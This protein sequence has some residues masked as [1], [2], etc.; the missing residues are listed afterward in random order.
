LPEKTVAI[1]NEIG[2]FQETQRGFEG[3]CPQCISLATCLGVSCYKDTLLLLGFSNS[4]LVSQTFKTVLGKVERPIV[5]RPPDYSKRL[6]IS[7]P[8]VWSI[9]PTSGLGFQGREGPWNSV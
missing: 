9:T 8:K 1:N 6:A 3:T 4:L 5:P 2:T 7:N